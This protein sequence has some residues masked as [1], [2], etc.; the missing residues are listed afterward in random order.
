MQRIFA[1]PSDL[2]EVRGSIDADRC[3]EGVA[4][5]TVEHEIGDRV[6]AGRLAVD[7]YQDGAVV[8]CHFREGGGGINH[9]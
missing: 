2:P 7:D 3:A 8:F 9:Q 6:E 5:R 4:D 1:A